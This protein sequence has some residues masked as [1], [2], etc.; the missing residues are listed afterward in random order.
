MQRQHGRVYEE[1]TNFAG[2]P[3]NIQSFGGTSE[4][5]PFIAGGAALVIQAYRA[6]HGGN[7]PSPSLVRQLLTSTATDLGEPSVEEGAGEMNTLAAVQAAR[8]RRQRPSGANGQHLLVSPN[9]RRSPVQAGSAVSKSVKVTN[10]GPLNQIVHA[11]AR[12]ITTQVS[13][14]TGR[15]T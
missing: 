2:Q 5:A 3:T 9:Q 7:T 14:Q 15:S 4:S 13:N 12:A 10:L 1:C 6:A 11:Q 8:G